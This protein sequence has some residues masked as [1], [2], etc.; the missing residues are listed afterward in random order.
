MTNS[1]LACLWSFLVL[2]QHHSE[3]KYLSDAQRWDVLDQFALLWGM[4]R[5]RVEAE[6]TERQAGPGPGPTGSR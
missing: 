2:A 4:D 5:M 1:Q 3:W 6:G